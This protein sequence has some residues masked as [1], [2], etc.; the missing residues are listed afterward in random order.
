MLDTKYVGMEAALL[1]AGYVV[2]GMNNT[3]QNCYGNAQCTQDVAGIVQLYRSKL[4]L[5]PQPYVLADSM[6]GFTLLNAISLR[7]IKPKAVVGLCLNTDLAWDFLEGHAA[8]PIT[9]AYNLSDANPYASAT[10]GYDPMLAGG[11]PFVPVAFALW[12]SYA[13]PIR[14]HGDGSGRR[15]DGT[16]LHRRAPR[17][18]QLRPSGSRGFF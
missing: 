8:V 15:C 1:A 14:S 6:G 17:P 3:L 12:S 13:D 7:S 11:K 5:A 10:S 9:A 16:Y 2:V 18:K 4:N